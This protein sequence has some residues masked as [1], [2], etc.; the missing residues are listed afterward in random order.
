MISPPMIIRHAG[1]TPFLNGANRIWYAYT[2]LFGWC[3]Y[4]WQIA[5]RTR[6]YWWTV[7]DN[8]IIVIGETYDPYYTRDDRHGEMIQFN[9]ICASHADIYATKRPEWA[10]GKTEHDLWIPMRRFDAAATDPKEAM[11]YNFAATTLL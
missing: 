10:M 9:M 6:V 1:I 11:H 8:I 3:M 4:R 5:T 2:M 7:L